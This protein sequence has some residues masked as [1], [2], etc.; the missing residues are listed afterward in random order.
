LEDSFGNA[1]AGKYES[2][3]DVNQGNPD[4]RYRKFEETI[5]EVFSS[6]M[7]E[8]ALSYR[9]QRGLSMQDEQ[10]ALLLQRVSGT[11]YKHYFLPFLAG[12]GFSRN[13]FVWH[14]DMDP[15]S[16][17]LRLVFGL[18]TRAVNRVE[19]DYPAIVALD[20]PQLKPYAGAKDQKRFSQHEVDVLNIDE[21]ELQSIGLDN[22]MSKEKAIEAGL[23][24][25]HDREAEAKLKEL[26]MAAESYI[27]DFNQ[28][29][30][31][32]NFITLMREMLKTME[33]AYQYPV[34]MEF[35]VNMRQGQLNVN[36]LQCRPLQARGLTGKVVIPDFSL[37]KIVFHSSGNFMGGN[38]NFPIKTVIQIDP[39]AY[40]KLLFNKK[41]E[42]ARLIGKLNKKFQG[43]DGVM[44]I[45]PGRW[46]TR[47][48]SLGVP[49]NFAEINNFS[50]LVEVADPASGF[51]PE[52]SFGSH[53]FL[54]LVETNIFYVALFT[55]EE[56]VVFQQDWLKNSTDELLKILPEAE[57]Y[58]E[59]IKVVDFSSR[60]LNLLSDVASQ[61]VICI[62]S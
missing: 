21:N 53:F 54:D 45:G 12:V 48:A 35:T 2:I 9:V 17:M 28:L 47:D 14:E 11:Q 10:M 15:R 32:T 30:A 23:V 31:K 46:G 57:P 55:Q 18:G 34:D 3:F 52:L 29:F 39:N 25:T 61:K 62:R 56:K 37:E 6:T 51:M 50:V 13:T 59:V 20:A 44:L 24:V 26:K 38:A 49:V 33:E 8:D 42:V 5:K 36:I 16:G 4:D 1:F 60:P 40:G 19:G 41:S 7:S 43:Q 58:K 27:I 22:L